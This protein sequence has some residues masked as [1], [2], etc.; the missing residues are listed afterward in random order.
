MSTDAPF[1]VILDPEHIFDRGQQFERQQ[2]AMTLW[3]SCWPEGLEVRDKSD[4]LR[5]QVVNAGGR[6]KACQHQ[7]LESFGG[8]VRLVAAGNNGNLRRVEETE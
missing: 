3:L 1:V 4:N 7:A 2:M 8:T 5:Y 6:I